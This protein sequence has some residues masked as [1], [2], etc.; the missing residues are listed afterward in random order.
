MSHAQREAAAQTMEH[1]CEHEW[2]G[3]AQDARYGDGEGYCDVDTAVG[4]VQVAQGD[5]D[6]TSSIADAYT[7][8]GVN[9]GGASWSGNYYDC[10][11]STGNFRAHR[12]SDGYNCDDGYVAQ[13]GD[14]Y[15]AHNDYWQ[16]AAMCTSSEPD[17]LAEFSINEWGGISNGQTGDQTGTESL[18]HGYYGGHWDWCFEALVGGDSSQPSQPSE[19]SGGS[20]DVSGAPMPRYRS[21][22]MEDGDKKWF[23]WMEGLSDTGNSGDDYAGE[24]GVSIVDIEFEN[25]GDGGWFILNVQGVGELAKNQQNNTGK[26]LIGVTVYYMTPNPSETGYYKAYYCVHWQGDKPSWGKWEY[27]DEDGGAGN[28]KDPIDMFKLTLSR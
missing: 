2:H 16:H 11:M 18:I 28:D 3:Y 19:P 6:C 1:L 12:M 26:P 8:V 25:L 22:Y 7:A 21:A 24:P 10:L 20:S 5:R 27:D 13:R 15:L 9:V 14:I 17:M 4:V 23:D